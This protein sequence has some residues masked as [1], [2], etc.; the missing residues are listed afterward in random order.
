MLDTIRK[1]SIAINRIVLFLAAIA[2]VTYFFPRQGKFGYEYTKGKPWPHSTLIAPFD[3]PI[4][5]TQAELKAE[6]EK[7]LSAFYPYFRFNEE[8]EQ[9]QLSLFEN[10]YNSARLRLISKYPFLSLPIPGRPEFDIFAG[11]RSHI[12]RL[13]SETYE[14]GIITLPEEYQDKPSSMIVSV[15]KNNFAERNELGELYNYPSAYLHLTKGLTSYINQRTTVSPR[16]IEQFIDDLQLNKYL[17]SNV[18]YDE[19]RTQHEKERVLADISLSSGVVLSGQRIID[20]G[21]L[22]ADENGKIL[23]SLKSEYES[24]LGAGSSHFIVLLGQALL[25][26]MLFTIVYYFLYYFRRDEFRNLKSVCFL[27]LLV[28]IMVILAQLAG[29]SAEPASIY[30]IPFAILPIIV[31]IFFD[32]RLA[33]FLHVTTIL[34]SATFAPNSFEFAIIQIPI[35]LVA[36]YSLYRMTRRSQLVRAA[37]LIILS[38][39]L[40]YTG[41]KLWQEGD[42]TRIDYSMYRNLAIN[43]G[44]L[45]LVYPL[46]YIF[47][48]LFG[49]LSDVTLVELSD[50]NHPILRRLAEK[51]PGTFQHSIQVGNLAQEAIYLIGGNPL[52]VRTGAMYH[53]I[54]KLVAPL[55]FTEN[56]THGINPHS[57]LPYEDSAQIIISHVE[58]GVKM[59]H[60]EKLPRQI[61]DFIETHHGTMKAKYFYN[62]YVNERPDEEVDVSL[63]CYPGPTPFTKETAVLMMADS[64]EAASRSLKSYSDDEID[65]LVENII[66][67]QMAENQFMDAP[68]TFKEINT[69]KDLFKQK[70]KNIYHARI[71]YPELKKKIKRSS[72]KNSD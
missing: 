39:S 63:F 46:I 32:S 28:V 41:L 14:K 10:D 72:E 35:G 20:T 58:N 47:E 65:R 57:E 19:A 61:I 38:Y 44:L 48:K 64:V 71:E 31:R 15:V 22:I 1:Y 5:K 27:L 51:A 21:E 25:I 6:R 37:I 49:F 40:L 4:Y 9:A 53:D 60:K 68:I 66:N 29:I 70:L 8:V 59:A 69:V 33:F 67:S 30:V 16:I 50:T 36:M 54:G 18:V 11:T 13:L 12:K 7:S 45:L 42:F 24:R 52:L 26:S 23:D 55:Y 3:F 62:M 43:G 17:Q 56:Q 2:I 34:L